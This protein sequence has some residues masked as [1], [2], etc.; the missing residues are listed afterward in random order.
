MKE[1][2]SIGEEKEYI[3]KELNAKLQAF[4]E[5]YDLAKVSLY[6]NLPETDKNYGISIL[7]HEEL[8]KWKMWAEQNTQQPQAI[9]DFRD[10]KQHGTSFG[11]NDI[12]GKE[13]LL[14]TG[15]ELCEHYE[16]LRLAYL[17]LIKNYEGEMKAIATQR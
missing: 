15:T 14:L 7:T 11:V 3:E 12:E 13:V 17:E 5:K 6:I 1:F 9:W 16:K 4:K 8:A 2:L 10:E